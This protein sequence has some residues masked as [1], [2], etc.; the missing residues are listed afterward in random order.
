MQKQGEVF[1]VPFTLLF[2]PFNDSVNHLR[3]SCDGVTGKSSTFPPEMAEGLDAEVCTDGRRADGALVRVGVVDAATEATEG[4]VGVATAV[5]LLPLE[6]TVTQALLPAGVAG[7]G[8][9]YKNPS[10]KV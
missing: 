1:C 7:I 2:R 3:N 4:R 6:P 9:V 10:V 5:L 8:A